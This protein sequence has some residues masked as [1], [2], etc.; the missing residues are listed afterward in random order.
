QVKFRGRLLRLADTCLKSPLLP[1]Y[2][3][4]AFLKRLARLALATPAPGAAVAL[5]IIYNLLRRHPACLPLIHRAVTF[6]EAE[7]EGGE[8]AN[9]GEAEEQEPRNLKKG[10]ARNLSRD[11]YRMEEPDPYKTGALQSSLWELQALRRHYCPAV[12]KVAGVFLDPITRQRPELSLA[13]AL[14]VSVASL[15]EEQAGKRAKGGQVALTFEVPATLLG[16]W[17][18][19]AEPEGEPSSGAGELVTVGALAPFFRL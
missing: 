6:D 8:S 13:E 2:L 4:A 7:A 5:P 15:V 18:G 3:V 16:A 17:P 12:A 11:P 19:V 1:A 9:G 14:Q 10:E